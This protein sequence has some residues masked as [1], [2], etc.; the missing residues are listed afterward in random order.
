MVETAHEVIVSYATVL[1]SGGV[2]GTGRPAAAD[3]THHDI[4][5]SNNLLHQLGG[6]IGAEGNPV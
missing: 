5:P 3:P 4:P 6:K 1:S 2:G